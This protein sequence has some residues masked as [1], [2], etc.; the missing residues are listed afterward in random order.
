MRVFQAGDD[1][2]ENIYGG[3]ISMAEVISYTLLAS[4]VKGFPYLPKM[5]CSGPS[6]LWRTVCSIFLAD[7][8]WPEPF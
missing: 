8:Y 7:A 5:T 4:P 3:K 1:E 6:F 2:A